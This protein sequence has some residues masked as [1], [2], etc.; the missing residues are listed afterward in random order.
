MTF[1][2][3]TGACVSV[4]V[5]IRVVATIVDVIQRWRSGDWSV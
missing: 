3:I 4:Y 2:G 1:L 5:G